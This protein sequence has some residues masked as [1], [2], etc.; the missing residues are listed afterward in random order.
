MKVFV[1]ILGSYLAI[2]W[3]VGVVALVRSR[4]NPFHLLDTLGPIK[5]AAAALVLWPMVLLSEWEFRRTCRRLSEGPV[6]TDWVVTDRQVPAGWI[7]AK[8]ADS[9]SEFDWE[10]GRYKRQEHP[11]IQD[12]LDL[13]VPDDEL[14]KF[15]SGKESWQHLAGRAGYVVLRKGQQVG[16]LTTVMN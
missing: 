2:G 16:H 7:T 13:M 6:R 4:K 8:V 1:T 10:N 9:P 11:G 5:S 3:V 12:L 14:W 15:N